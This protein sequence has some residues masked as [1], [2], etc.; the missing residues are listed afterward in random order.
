VDKWDLV[1]LFAHKN[2]EENVDMLIKSTVSA[3]FDWTD[4]RVLSTNQKI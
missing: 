3:L 1:H 4:K 2:V